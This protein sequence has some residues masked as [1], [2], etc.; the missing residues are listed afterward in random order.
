[1][2]DEVKE[3]T[4]LDLAI[5]RYFAGSQKQ[6]AAY[7]HVTPQ[8]VGQWV[9]RGFLPLEQARKVNAR[10]RRVSIKSLADPELVGSLCGRRK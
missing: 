10:Y 3:P 1:M 8:A 9:K 5:A 7:L 2:Q 4:A 6:L